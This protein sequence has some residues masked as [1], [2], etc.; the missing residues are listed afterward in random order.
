LAAARGELAEHRIALNERAQRFIEA[1]SAAFEAARRRR[2]R[3]LYGVFSGLAI[4]SLILGALSVWAVNAQQ[5][6]QA[7]AAEAQR[8][9]K[10]SHSR[11]LAAIAISQI[12][13]DPERS[14]LIAIKANE[15]L[16]TF[17]SQDALRQA[18]LSFHLRL[19]L[20]SDNNPVY[21][22]QYSPDGAYI[23]TS[24][25][26]GLRGWNSADGQLLFSIP[27][28]PAYAIDF[29]ADGTS[30]VSVHTD[31]IARVWRVPAGEQTGTLDST[32]GSIDQAL[33]SPDGRQI[34]TTECTE[35]PQ[36]FCIRS[37]VRLWN[38]ATGKPAL[39]LTSHEAV[40][41]SAQFSPNVNRLVTTGCEKLSADDRCIAGTV[42][43][44]DAN[45]GRELTVL[46]GFGNQVDEV[47]ISPDGSYLA[48]LHGNLDHTLSLWNAVSGKEIVSLRGQDGDVRGAV[49]SPDGRKILAFGSERTTRG[50]WDPAVWVLMQASEV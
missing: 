44:W 31:G 13:I 33:F 8:Q 48:T 41:Y 26:D 11:E 19:V 15:D 36:G 12:A 40:V 28:F 34:V 30:I 16:S 9:Q 17:E 1:S 18:L 42:R 37:T 22:A 38:A 14:I 2:R 43:V 49:F 27:A 29:S 46:Q 47:V 23:V 39:V 35:R 50:P 7:N 10:I 20:N 45:T 32:E 6:A 3:I 4:V 21:F 25:R 24:Q 5:A